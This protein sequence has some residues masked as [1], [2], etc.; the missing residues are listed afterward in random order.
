MV[1][2]IQTNVATRDPTRCQVRLVT[3][4]NLAG[5]MEPD[6]VNCPHAQSFGNGFFCRL[7]LRPDAAGG[8]LPRV[9]Q[10]AHALTATANPV[11]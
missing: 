8:K 9:D 3:G 10:H 11:A 2:Q 1:E 5:C 6:A 4:S 7:F